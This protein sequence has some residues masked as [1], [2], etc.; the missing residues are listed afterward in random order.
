MTGSERYLNFFPDRKKTRQAVNNS[1][2]E[3]AGN[4]LRWNTKNALQSAA[5]ADGSWERAFLAR[6]VQKRLPSGCW[7]ESVI[8]ALNQE[9]ITGK[10]APG[11]GRELS[12]YYEALVR[13]PDNFRPF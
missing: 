2:N 7:C 8:F 1:F 6:H 3:M 10:A 12:N 4:H 13:K 11:M 5:A 9:I